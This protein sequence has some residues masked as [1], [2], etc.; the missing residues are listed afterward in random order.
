M[1]R[2]RSAA[3]FAITWVGANGNSSSSSR[4][5]G[6]NNNVAVPLAVNLSNLQIEKL[7]IIYNLAKLFELANAQVLSASHKTFS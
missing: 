5:A 6:N 4:R 7:Q 1:L 3:S 2:L